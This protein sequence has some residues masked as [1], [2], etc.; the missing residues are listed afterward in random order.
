[1][2]EMKMLEVSKAVDDL[3]EEARRKLGCS[4]NQLLQ[5]AVQLYC[6]RL[7]VQRKI[8]RL[9]AGSGAAVAQYRATRNLEREIAEVVEQEVQSARLF[10]GDVSRSRSEGPTS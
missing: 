1:M 9:L 2:E 10:E 4:T 7:G 3:I 8:Q 6:A 5:E